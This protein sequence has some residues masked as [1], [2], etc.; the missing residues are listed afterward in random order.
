MHDVLRS[1]GMS[2]V[3][4]NRICPFGKPF[5]GLSVLSDGYAL[6]KGKPTDPKGL[7]EYDKIKYKENPQKI[8]VAV[9]SKDNNSFIHTRP[10]LN[11]DAQM[12]YVQFV[13]VHK[14]TR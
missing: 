3:T 13:A 8:P 1:I 5:K 6:L 9:H 10:L 2:L 14:C 12:M 11:R 4:G 7:G